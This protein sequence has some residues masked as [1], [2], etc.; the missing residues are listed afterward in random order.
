MFEH[1]LPA[2]VMGVLGIDYKRPA[3]VIERVIVSRLII[4]H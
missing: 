1:G 3:R 2:T 4:S